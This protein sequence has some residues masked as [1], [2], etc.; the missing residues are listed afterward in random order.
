MIKLLKIY[1]TATKTA[2]RK[3]LYNRLIG[4][5]AILHVNM[6]KM[7]DRHIRDTKYLI[8]TYLLLFCRDPE[9]KSKHPA[10]FPE[11]LAKNCIIYYS[12]EGD[13]IL[14]PFAGSGTVGKMAKQLNRNCILIE[15]E[16]EYI[17]IAEKRINENL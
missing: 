9:T 3:F 12:Y 2:V 6:E 13:T 1:I 10:P 11:K 16:M 4:I 7:I 5:A 15:K 17:E 8:E 14:D